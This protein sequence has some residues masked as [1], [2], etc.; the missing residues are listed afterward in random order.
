MN[1]YARLAF[2]IAPA[3]VVAIG[4]GAVLLHEREARRLA[5]GHHATK[6]R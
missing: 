3:L 6:G 1:E 2:V 5:H 4:Y